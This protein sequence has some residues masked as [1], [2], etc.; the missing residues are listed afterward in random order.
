MD[1]IREKAALLLALP[2]DSQADTALLDFTASLVCDTICNYCNLET[3]PPGL[4]HVAAAMAADA[5]RQ[6]QYGRAQPEAQVKGVSRGDTSFS[7]ATPAEQ[8]REIVQSPGF[9]QDYRVQLRQF[10]KVRW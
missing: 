4:I 9:T 7:F 2:P 5:W 10:R 1:A 6:S 8:L 3:V